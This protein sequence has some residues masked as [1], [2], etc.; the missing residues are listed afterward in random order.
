MELLQENGSA[1]KGSKK[2]KFFLV[3]VEKTPEKLFVN[4]DYLIPSFDTSIDQTLSENE[5]DSIFVS[6]IQLI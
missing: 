3:W 1:V 4:R 6:Q 2:G 5:S